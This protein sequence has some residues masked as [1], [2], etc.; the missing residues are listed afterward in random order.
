MKAV[1]L[2]EWGAGAA[3]MQQRLGTQVHSEVLE[4]GRPC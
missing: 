4:L 1:S 2:P 3:I